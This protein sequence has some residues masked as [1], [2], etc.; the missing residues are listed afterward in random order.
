MLEEDKNSKKKAADF[1]PS[2]DKMI[3]RSGNAVNMTPIA[4]EKLY[5]KMVEEISDY[6]ILLLDTE[7]HILNWNQGAAN[8]KG[9]S[10]DE[11]IGKNF[12]VFY[13]TEDRNNKVPEQLL[14]RALKEGRASHEGWRLK[15][16]GSKFWG[17][18][19]I[20]ALH[21]DDGNVISFSKVTRDLTE[22]K[23][24]EEKQQRNSMDLEFKNEELRRSEERYH[25]MI[26][27]IEDYAIILLDTDGK[28]VNWNKGAQSIKGYAAEEVLGR[29]FSIFYLQED[30][31]SGLPNKLITEARTKGKASHEGWRVKKDGNTFWGSIVITALHDTENNIVGFSKVTR[32]LSERKKAEER[33]ERYTV[34]LQYQNEML[35]RSEERYQRMIAEVEDYAIILLDKNGDI[36]NWNKGAEKIK[37]YSSDE[38][39]GKN[40]STFY[41]PED[42]ATNLP[43]R[44]L[45]DAEKNDKAVH[46]GWRVRKD[47]TRFWGSIIITA[48]HGDNGELIGYSKVTRDL[49]QKKQFE[50]FILL[51]NKQLEEYAYVASHDLQEPLRKIRLFSDSVADKLDDR[52]TALQLLDKINSSAERM[53]VL[54]KAVLQYSQATISDE[55]KERVDL[56]TI[57]KEIETDFELLL[58]EKK[59]TI[60]YENLP[61]VIGV[62][63]QMHQL[64]S[65]LIINSIKYSKKNPEIRITAEPAHEV[66]GKEDKY[67]KLTVAD[68]GIGFHQEN[69]EK[70]F[71]MFH[72]L[73][74]NSYKG[75]GI[76]LALCKRIVEGHGGTINAFSSPGEGSR[77]EIML[78]ACHVPQN[79]PLDLIKKGSISAI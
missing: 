72:R 25:R 76:G 53:A 65:N 27:E 42:R 52:E 5:H 32:D 16:D 71:K 48:L 21:D 8:I 31:A 1:K 55:L 22:R 20:T 13:V 40:F 24:G 77:F 78:P 43:A 73:P 26:S 68:N 18:I 4:V 66:P 35:R 58:H 7:G 6:A 60:F 30:I 17:S 2:V 10:A 29:N 14:D 28:I 44:L 51:Q 56:N 19:V 37:G 63:I 36:L 54:I 39:L 45:A 34:E 15:K 57:L 69:A 50:D 41:L 61:A 49:T 3:N 38:I 11:I 79:N 70:M 74:Q 9:Y 59:A 47:G 75:T 23:A 67:F 46:E 12:R 64:F 33:L 62:P